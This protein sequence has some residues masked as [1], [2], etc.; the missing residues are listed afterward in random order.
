MPYLIVIFSILFLFLLYLFLI[1]GRVIKGSFSELEKFDYAHRGLHGNGVPEN[2]LNAFNLALENGYGAELDVHLLADGS[3]AVIH[4]SDLLRTTGKEGV[5]EDLT[6]N[7]LKNYNLESTKET[8]P[9]LREVLN[10]FEEKTPLVIELKTYKNNCNKLCESVCK[11]LENYK[12]SFCIESFDPRCLMWLKRNKPEIIRG[13]LAQNFIKK[14]SG[15]KRILDFIL[16]SLVLNVATR[17]DF[18][19]YKFEDRKNLSNLISTKFLKT[20]GFSWTITD[21]DSYKTSKNENLSPIFEKIK[22]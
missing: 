2:S 15:Q 8:I 19:A 13:Q 7:D 21:N 6:I 10:I 1:S 14:P 12:G 5:I 20:K 9:T 16:T 22:P 17:P 4:D 3:L 18:I 11:E